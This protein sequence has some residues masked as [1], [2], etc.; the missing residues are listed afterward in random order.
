VG[1]SP[2]ALAGGNACTAP[3]PSAV[4]VNTRKLQSGGQVVEPARPTADSA[5]LELVP[6]PLTAEERKDAWRAANFYDST[7]DH[8][9]PIALWILGPS[10]VGKSTL[11]AEVGGE[12]DIPRVFAAGAQVEVGSPRSQPSVER[13][14]SSEDS[15]RCLDAVV[16]DGEFMRDTHAVWQQWVGTEDWRSA[17]PALKAVIN[18]E[19]DS[20]QDAAVA[21]RKHLIIP[22]TVL[23]LGKGIADLG[24][25]V[26]KGYINHVLAVVAPLK[27]CQRRGH[28]R[29]ALTGKRY[30]PGEYERSIQAIP[31]MVEACNGR[32]QLIRALE[33]NEGSKKRMGYRL[34]SAGPCGSSSAQG[35]LNMPTPNFNAD[36]LS[37]VIDENIRAP[38]I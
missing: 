1:A 2:R 25:L 27:E 14:L 32:Y 3:V 36:F 4:V 23:N 29:E 37:R 20:L 28:A 22:Q 30:Q 38:I 13:V 18:Q 17:Y 31:P 6:R 24:R 26:G 15:R 16:V 34:L 33:M 10:S 12:F 21:E 35:E 19:K 5:K 11:T 7:S 9:R 8:P